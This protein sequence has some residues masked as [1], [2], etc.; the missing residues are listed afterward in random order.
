MSPAHEAFRRKD[1]IG[2][3]AASIAK[4]AEG[5]GPVRLMHVC[6]THE[7]SVNRYGLRSLLPPNVKIVAGPGC[8]VC[9]CP[10]SELLAA[11]ALAL[12]PATILASFGDMLSVPMPGGSLLGARREGAELRVVYSATDALALARAEPGKEIV[13]FSVGFETTAATSASLISSLGRLAVPNFSLLSSNRVV[14]K[15]LE[16]LL[17][18]NMLA[19]EG[20]N[21]P[22][23][24]GLILPGHVSAIIGSEAYRSLVEDFGIPSVVAGFEPL[25]L[26][27]AIHDL[28]AQKRSGRAELHNAYSRAVLPEGNAKAKELMAEVFEL[29]D[30]EWRG[31]GLLPETGLGLKPAFSAY[32]AS[33]KFGDFLRKAEAESRAGVEAE[34][35]GCLCSRVVLGLAEPEDC[36]HF[37]S[38]CRQESPL[39]PCMVS[40]EGTCRIRLEYG[41][42]M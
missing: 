16:A 31:L 30:V 38:A 24:D 41:D 23:I 4:E 17:A 27:E 14:P 32:D 25:D 37:G 8:P 11:R 33:V 13:F 10:L 22:S 3:L 18:S 40:E 21:G 39:G 19:A 6:G 2:N 35:K 15:A 28:L 34:T 12:R 7:R 20:R 1:L 26:L 36:P 29:R 5:L 9:V 42:A